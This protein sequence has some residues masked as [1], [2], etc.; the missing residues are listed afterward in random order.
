MIQ[1]PP[2]P[3]PPSPTHCWPLPLFPTCS[4]LTG[5]PAQ[6]SNP[7]DGTQTSP[8][9]PKVFNECTGT[10]ST[11]YQNCVSMCRSQV[12]AKGIQNKINCC[13]QTGTVKQ[14]GW[15]PAHGSRHS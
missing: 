10:S 2:L 5:V 4:Q 8:T 3:C 7:C 15:G 12:S 13:C 11:A 1:R 9:N 14:A 6:A